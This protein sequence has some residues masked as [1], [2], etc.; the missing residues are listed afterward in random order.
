M[1]KMEKYDCNS[2]QDYFATIVSLVKSKGN[3][4][5][6][7]FTDPKALRLGVV[8]F[9]LDVIVTFQLSKFN[10]YYDRPFFIATREQIGLAQKNYE[11]DSLEAFS[12]KMPVDRKK[13]V[14]GSR[15]ETTKEKIDDVECVVSRKVDIKAGDN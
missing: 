12:G 3:S 10:A 8:N 4:G 1:E 9:D 2:M 11:S 7:P 14:I 13:D 6:T 15:W 5:F